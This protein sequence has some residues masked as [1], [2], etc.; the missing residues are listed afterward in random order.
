MPCV[1]PVSWRQH[2]EQRVCYNKN[3]QKKRY[4]APRQEQA[5][6]RK[7]PEYFAAL[8]LRKIWCEGNFSHRKAEHNLRRTYKRGIERVTEQ[9]L[10]SACT[11][12]LIRLVKAA[13]AVFSLYMEEEHRG[14]SI[15]FQQRNQEQ[16]QE[17]LWEKQAGKCIVCLMK[18]EITTDFPNDLLVH[19]A[20]VQEKYETGYVI[21]RFL[22]CASSKVRTY[23]H[24][25]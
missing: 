18:E 13:N 19:L 6:H 14:L 2:R 20:K 8:R 4:Q 1:L 21:S 15:T 3:G 16:C 10:L 5:K 23:R 17:T 22:T 11:M 25:V 12:N 24:A 7:T 9:C